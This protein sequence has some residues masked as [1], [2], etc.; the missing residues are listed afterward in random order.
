M[1]PRLLFDWA[2]DNITAV[3]FILDDYK[4]EQIL[5]EQCFKQSQ[6]LE[7]HNIFVAENVHCSWTLFN[8]Q[9]KSQGLYS[10]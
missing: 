3:A 5:L 9:A 10:A 6:F 2:V 4:S 1:T 8:S 7:W